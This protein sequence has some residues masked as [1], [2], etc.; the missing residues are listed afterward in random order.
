MT[1]ENQK[2]WLQRLKDESWEAEILVSAVAIFAILNSFELL[3]W[4]VNKFIENLGPEQYTIAYF[5]VVMGYL[6]I[7]ILAAMFTLHFALRAYWIGLVGLNSVFPDYSLEDSAY[8]PIYTKKM[9][10]ILP[11]LS[12]SIDKVDELCSVIFS[13]AFALMLIYAY[14][15]VFAV[16]YL[17]LYNAL[18]SLVPSWL[19]LLPLLLI[20]VFT[21]LGMILGIAANLKQFKGNEKLQHY[22]FLYTKW[23]GFILY[24]PL[25]KSVL[26]IT[27]TFAS[28]FK[29]KK[30][31][32]RL[33]LVMLLSG[34]AFTLF[35][36]TAS[37]YSYLIKPDATVD[38]G[39][40]Y[41]EFYKNLNEKESFLLGPEINSNSIHTKT[42][43]LFVPVFEYEA[44]SMYSYCNLE[45]PNLGEKEEDRKK[46]WSQ[47]LDCYQ[48]LHQL[49]LDDKL[50][51][52][53]F[54][55]TQHYRTGQFGIQCY[56]DLSSLTTDLHYLKIERRLG[57]GTSK[58][59]TIPF[60]YSANQ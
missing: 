3:H 2:S 43:E 50:I 36:M 8:S 30:A 22:Y 13:A 33:I 21:V 40:Q 26:M 23:N 31:L 6:G 15:T 7:G 54:L 58:E 47:N 60:Y 45:E 1:K 35:K 28:N 20:G 49:Y 52:S 9:L 38:V 10:G 56:V 59:W 18:V 11:K 34:F 27:M 25:H 46:R 29:K 19:L 12:D 4:M 53:K 39:R 14:L 16:V 5:I 37:N 57:N 48:Q 55:K 42:L 51:T 17:F 32:V 44:N 41:S 24:G